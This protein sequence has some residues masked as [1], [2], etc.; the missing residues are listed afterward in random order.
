MAAMMNK[1]GGMTM[2]TEV[3]SVSSDAIADSMF[4]V[5]AGYKTKQR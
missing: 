4:D 3:V 2:L 1:M 5:P